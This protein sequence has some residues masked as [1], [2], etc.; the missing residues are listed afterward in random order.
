MELD[1]DLRLYRDVSV[2]GLPRFN[3]TWQPTGGDP[4]VAATLQEA[5]AAAAGPAIGRE[6]TA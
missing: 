3:A 2:N 1:C 4:L 5:C 6:P